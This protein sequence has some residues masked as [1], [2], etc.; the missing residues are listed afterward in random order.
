[1]TN[2]EQIAEILQT[3]LQS[4]TALNEAIERLNARLSALEARTGL[5]KPVSLADR[6]RG[7][8]DAV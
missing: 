1:M 8:E 2:L 4:I 5:P 3:N 6:Q 7:G